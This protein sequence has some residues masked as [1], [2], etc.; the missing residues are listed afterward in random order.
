MRRKRGVTGF[1]E[2]S[3]ARP[4]RARGSESCT[5]PPTAVFPDEAPT[6]AHGVCYAPNTT[7]AGQPPSSPLT[8]ASHSYTT[9]ILFKKQKK[10]PNILEHF[11]PYHGV[12]VGGRTER[13][14]TPGAGAAD[15]RQGQMPERQARHTR[16]CSGGSLTSLKADRQTCL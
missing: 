4:A 12:G 5:S 10:F 13:E 14:T 16:P 11:L 2:P 1:Q 7:G 15:F 6:R 3:T 9:N 8:R